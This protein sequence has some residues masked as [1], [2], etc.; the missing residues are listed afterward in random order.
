[1]KVG[2]TGKEKEA[3]AVRTAMTCADGRAK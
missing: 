2:D 3:V 1:L